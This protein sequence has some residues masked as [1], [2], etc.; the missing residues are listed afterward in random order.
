VGATLKSGRC[1]DEAA[2][3]QLRQIWSDATTPMGDSAQEIRRDVLAIGRI[4]AVPMLLRIVSET[5]GMGFALHKLS[6]GRV[7]TQSV[8]SL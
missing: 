6:T 3:W 5:S 1:K 2:R 4:E 7:L 8:S